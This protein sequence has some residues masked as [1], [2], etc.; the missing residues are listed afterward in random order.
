[1]N[2]N[3]THERRNGEDRRKHSITPKFPFYDCCGNLVTQDRRNL[4][5][6]RLVGFSVEWI[7]DQELIL[8]WPNLPENKENSAAII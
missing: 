6:R 4:P 8:V 7:S 5:D 3:D 2:K 1:M